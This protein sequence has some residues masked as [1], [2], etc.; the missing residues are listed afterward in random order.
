MGFDLSVYLTRAEF[1]AFLEK[2]KEEMEKF[3]AWLLAELKKINDHLEIHDQQI[4]E[5]QQD[6][7]DINTRIDNLI[8]EYNAKFEDIYN[9][10]GDLNN[11]IEGSI[12]N[13]EQYINNKIKEILNKINQSGSNISNEYK[14]YF[15]SNYVSMFKNKIRPGTNIT[16]VENSD[17][18]ITINAA[19]GG[20]GGGGLTEEEVRNII[21]SILNNY[22]TK[23]E[24]NDIIA[25][26]KGGGGSGGDGTH[27]V[28][29]TTQ[30]G[31]ARTGKYLV[32]NKFADS[33][34]KPSRLD[35]DFNSLYTDI[36]IN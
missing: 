10:I 16:F 22:Y 1:E 5:L 34:T 29:S 30:L 12:N 9:K 17:G 7:T 24:I 33:E 19:G 15:E 14:Q 4:S 35:V 8:T 6:I 11:N 28:M 20:S 26:L 32:M 13:L 36:K 31:E 25:G 23:Q 21:N 18:T 27:N 3:Y 2:L